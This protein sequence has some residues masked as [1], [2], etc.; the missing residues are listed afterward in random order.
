M[1]VWI[2]CQTLPMSLVG[3]VPSSTRKPTF[4]APL[5]A[6]MLQITKLFTELKL[7]VCF[8]LLT[9]CL[10][11][12]SALNSR[13]SSLANL[14]KTLLPYMV[15]LTS[16]KSSRL[17]ALLKWPGSWVSSNT[18]DGRLKDGS[19]YVGWVDSKTNEP[20]DDKDIQGRY[21]KGIL[22]HAGV[23]LI[24]GYLCFPRFLEFNSL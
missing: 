20:I 9:F 13:T 22:A 21:E 19:L 17:K 14:C 15:S 24:G 12:T 10:V 4:I 7:N 23:R 6:T 2:A 1:A 18:F 5:P 3:S 8:N 16:I 11:L